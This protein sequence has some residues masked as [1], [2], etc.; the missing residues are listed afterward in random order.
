MTPVIRDLD[1]RTFVREIN[2]RIL[3][4]GFDYHAKPAF[5]DGTIPRKPLHNTQLFM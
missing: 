4:G 5:Q 2:G 1:S 3:G